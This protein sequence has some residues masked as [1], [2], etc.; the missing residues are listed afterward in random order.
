[1][2]KIEILFIVLC[3]SLFC[4]GS[5]LAAGSVTGTLT[6]PYENERILELVWVWAA[7][8]GTVS[9]YTVDTTITNELQPFYI[10]MVCTVPG[11]PPPTDLYGITLVDKD[12]ID[13]MGGVLSGRS[14]TLTQCV[15]PIIDSSTSTK[16][17]RPMNGAMTVNITSTTDNSATGTI[18]IFL[19]K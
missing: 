13:M 17:G 2:K 5:C 11:T 14:R 10:F 1:M 15:V 9:A 6:R 19:F 8:G 7:S 12:S 3:F 18:R 4:A 16:G